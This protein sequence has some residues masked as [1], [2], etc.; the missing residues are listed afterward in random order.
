MKRLYLNAWDFVLR[1][2]GRC[3]WWNPNFLLGVQ[4]ARIGAPV[5]LDEAHGGEA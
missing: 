2:F 5:V 4:V 1:P 3:A